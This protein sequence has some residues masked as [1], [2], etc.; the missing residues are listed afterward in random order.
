MINSYRG[1]R[2]R[3][4]S[5]DL[6]VSPRDINSVVNPVTMSANDILPA[7]VFFEVELF[8]SSLV[9]VFEMSLVNNPR[10]NPSI[11]STVGSWPADVFK[12]PS[13][14]NSFVVAAAVKLDDATGV[15]TVEDTVDISISISAA[16]D[17]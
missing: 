14:G 11:V 3:I 8:G 10:I 13:D 1:S 5:A 4:P 17:I 15:T 9:A 6:S 7:D 2:S 12:A 16:L